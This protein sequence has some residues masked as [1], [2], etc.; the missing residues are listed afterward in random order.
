MCNCGTLVRVWGIAGGK[1]II[2]ATL[3]GKVWMM[4]DRVKIFIVVLLLLL[5]G[6]PLAGKLVR[7]EKEPPAPATASPS[8]AKPSWNVSKAAP[9]Q[10]THQPAPR[11]APRVSQPAP[12]RRAQPRA[13]VKRQ[14]QL[15]AR[16]LANS[17]WTISDPQYGN[18]TI[19]LFGNGTAQAQSDKYPVRVEG[20]WRL[21]GST[22]NVSGSA[23]GQSF[24]F[25]AQ[26]VGNQIKAHGRTAR[27]LR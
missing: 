12:Q 3:H 11:P 23:F 18:V 20:K 21:S 26:V 9:P 22:L 17:V 16:D 13:P 27:R 2:G 19:Q 14:R 7:E 10:P 5:I 1:S 24:S 6:I 25:S 8:P 4:D 15:T